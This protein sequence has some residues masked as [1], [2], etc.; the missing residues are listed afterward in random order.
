MYMYYIVKDQ[1]M[2][3]MRA[4]LLL[5]MSTRD[6]VPHLDR[7]RRELTRAMPGD[8]LVV[9]RPLQEV[10]ENQT[11]AWRLG[12]TLFVSFGGLAFVVAIVGLY[13]VIS[14]GVAGRMHELGVRAALG[15]RPRHVIALVVSRGVRLTAAGVVLGGGVALLAS[16][17]V[18]PLLFKVP[19]RDPITYLAVIGVM[20]AVA[21]V[22]SLI[23][24]LRAVRADPM[25]ALRAD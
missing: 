25:Q 23:P 10:V 12:A 19:G 21:V 14:Y 13:G 18:E 17:W 11:R 20:L 8:G 1:F 4:P 24:A 22:A 3:E 7:V 16:R 6:V 15:A 2:R 9:V 5:R